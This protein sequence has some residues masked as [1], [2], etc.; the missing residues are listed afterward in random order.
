MNVPNSC[1]KNTALSYSIS[2]YKQDC[3]GL[4]SCCCRFRSFDFLKRTP[5]SLQYFRISGQIDRFRRRVRDADIT[6][7]TRRAEMCCSNY[8]LRTIYLIFCNKRTF[9]CHTNTV[10]GH[11][12]KEQLNSGKFSSFLPLFS[13]SVRRAAW[14][15]LIIHILFRQ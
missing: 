5:P 12:R 1:L 8:N 7:C 11:T 9:L 3:F 2:S 4:F 10:Q 6:T 14:P 13:S 15:K